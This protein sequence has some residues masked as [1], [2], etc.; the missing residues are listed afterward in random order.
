VR[1]VC[2]GRGGDVPPVC[3]GWG[4]DVRPICTAGGGQPDQL[5]ALS[6]EVVFV[7]HVRENVRHDVVPAGGPGQGWDSAGRR[8]AAGGR[9]FFVREVACPRGLL[10]RVPPGV[11]PPGIGRAGRYVRKV[12]PSQ[13]ALM[14]PTRSR[15][16]ARARAS[17][18][19]AR[20]RHHH[21]RPGDRRASGLYGAGERRAS[22]LYG[23]GTRRAGRGGNRRKSGRRAG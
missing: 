19:A 21:G 14:A 12:S 2:T 6:R 11:V 8:A 9:S 23:M 10:R 5:D 22:G 16:P 18:C 15:S 3:T 13:N 20:R 1:P 17:W 7:E 4:R